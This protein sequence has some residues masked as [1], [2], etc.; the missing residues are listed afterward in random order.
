MVS[1]CAWQFG[2]KLGSRGAESKYKVQSIPD[3]KAFPLPFL[4]DDCALFF[5]RV[6]SMQQEALD[7]IKAW[8]FVLKTELVWIKTTP[9]GKRHFGMG[10][11]TRAAHE[12]CLIATRGRPKVLRH[13]IR[14]VFEAPVPRLNGKI[15][16]S[17]KPDEFF[18]IAAAL[19]DGPRASIFDR[20]HRE[21][22]D[23]FG[24]EL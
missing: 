15:L 1:D 13:D 4:A 6:A 12:T 2:D 8:Q 11:I 24:D 3:M 23:C 5:W 22:F 21:G 9:T 7:V 10:Y 17:A 18:A 16:H 14:S 20:K 19:Y